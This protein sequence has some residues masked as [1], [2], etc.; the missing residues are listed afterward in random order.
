MIY[1]I[2]DFFRPI[3]VTDRIWNQFVDRGQVP[4]SI[5]RL[6]AFK[7]IKRE[8]LTERE[9]AIFCAKTDAI[10]NMIIQVTTKDI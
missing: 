5:I 9:F 4:D 6:L 10:N 7:T 8:N 3:Q 2:K 1:L